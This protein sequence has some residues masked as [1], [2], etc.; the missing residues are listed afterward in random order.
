VEATATSASPGAEDFGSRMLKVLRRFLPDTARIASLR[1]LSGGA[2]QETWSLVAETRA[3]PERL[4][5]RRTS[6]SANSQAKVAIET[7]AALMRAAQGAGVPSPDVKYVIAPEDELGRGFFMSHVDGETLGRRIV[8]DDQFATIRPRLAYLAGRILAKVH[9]IDVSAFVDLQ[10]RSPEEIVESLYRDYRAWSERRPVFELAFRWIRERM[11]TPE[12]A[13]TL[14][15]GDFRNGNL[16]VR[17]DG[18]AAVLDW[19]L[20]H[21]GD[22]LSDLGWLCTGAWRFSEIDKPVGGFG[23][24]GDLIAGYEAAGGRRVD[25]EALKFWEVL[26]S[27][28]WGAM[29][30]GMGRHARHSDRPVEHAMIGRRASENE[31]D[32]LRLLAP[33]GD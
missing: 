32:I 19:E 16:I 22:P 25:P 13:P 26:G 17:P 20:A 10:R 31:I 21:V 33:R 1:R 2:S 14:A 23:S 29:C 6:N 30:M 3:A 4:I 18:I 27:L 8:R 24:R 28:R 11:P 5:L 9:S 12:S 7:E 15:H